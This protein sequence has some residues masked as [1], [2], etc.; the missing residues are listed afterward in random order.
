MIVLLVTYIGAD[1]RNVKVQI[2]GPQR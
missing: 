1:A 2:S